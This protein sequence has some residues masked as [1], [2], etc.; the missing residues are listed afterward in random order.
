MNLTEHNTL[1]DAKWT[2]LV[3]DMG[4]ARR[5]QADTT[6]AARSQPSSQIA[7]RDVRQYL[8]SQLPDIVA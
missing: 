8:A 4:G 1:N 5:S 6:S 3:L 7:L 2:A